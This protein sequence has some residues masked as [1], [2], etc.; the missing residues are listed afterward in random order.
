MKTKQNATAFIPES[1]LI[2][3]SLSLTIFNFPVALIFEP[4]TTILIMH[5]VKLERLSMSATSTLV[6]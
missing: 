4:F 1:D 3:Y 5:H 2:G 6:F